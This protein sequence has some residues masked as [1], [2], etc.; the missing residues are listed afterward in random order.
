VAQF[1]LGDERAILGGGLAFGRILPAVQVAQDL[2]DSGTPT[3]FTEPRT[4][5]PATFDIEPRPT[6]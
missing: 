4:A 2:A 5:Q 3:V 1:A 6:P